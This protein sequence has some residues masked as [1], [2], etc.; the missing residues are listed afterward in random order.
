MLVV[1]TVYT[2]H[3]VWKPAAPTG[4]QDADRMLDSDSVLLSL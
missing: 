4:E 2:Q 1:F 3:R